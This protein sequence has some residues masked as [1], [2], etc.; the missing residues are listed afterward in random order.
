MYYAGESGVQVPAAALIDYLSPLPAAERITEFARYGVTIT[1]AARET[2][3]SPAADVGAQQETSVP[4]H[5][6][7]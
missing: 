6:G 1:P 3:A 7:A 4:A 2:A 5:P